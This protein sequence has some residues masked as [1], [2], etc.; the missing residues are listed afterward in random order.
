MND[1]NLRFFRFSGNV[2]A[3]LEGIHLSNLPVPT[4]V[5]PVLVI[6]FLKNLPKKAS[7]NAE[8]LD[9]VKSFSLINFIINSSRRGPR[10]NSGTHFEVRL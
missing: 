10:W 9:F 3:P 5:W 2:P 4:K 7:Q 6:W 1:E 8:N